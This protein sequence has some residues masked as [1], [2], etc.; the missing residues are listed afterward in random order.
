MSLLLHKPSR[1][2]IYAYSNREMTQPAGR[3][4]VMYNPDS[5]SLSY[6]TEYVPDLFINTTRQSNRYVQ[7]CPGGLS[8]ELL[9]D[10]QMPGN[11]KSIDS[12]LTDLKMLCYNVSP[13]QSEPRYLQVKWGKM[14]WN[15]RGYFSGRISGLSIRYTLFDRDATPLRATVTLELTADGSL[16]LQGAEEQLLSPESAVVKVPDITSL[17]SIVDN[18]GYSL[19]GKTDYLTVASENN[20]DALDAIEPGQVLRISVEQGATS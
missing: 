7:T 1:L 12:Q 11:H 18:A 3:L 16:E 6:Q 15:G 2:M 13:A 20:L 17:T 5:I 19:A 10:S 9:L 8:L 14:R 4:S